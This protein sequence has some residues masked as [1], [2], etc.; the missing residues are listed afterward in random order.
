[1]STI[2]R[3]VG[4]G[5]SATAG[6]TVSVSSFGALGNG[7][8]DDTNAIQAAINAV[9][10][11]ATSIG[12]DTGGVV[13]FPLG[14]YRC[15]AKLSVP[16]FVY[17][18]GEAAYASKLICD[19]STTI[20]RFIE[21]GATG[22]ISTFCGLK[23]LQVDANAK[24][25]VAVFLNGP[26][27]GA[28]VSEVW[29]K[30]ARVTGI[31]VDADTVLGTANKFLVERCWIWTAGDT[32][33]AGMKAEG[34]IM[35]VRSTTFVGTLRSGTYPTGGPAGSAGII[36]TDGGM[37]I[38]DVNCEHWEAAFSLVRASVELR[39]VTAFAV[40]NGVR[41][42]ADN[43]GKS[44]FLTNAKWDCSGDDIVDTGNSVSLPDAG[45]YHRGVTVGQ[46]PHWR[47]NWYDYQTVV[48]G[49]GNSVK[50]KVG[51]QSDADADLTRFK[52]SFLGP[53]GWR[54]A[55]QIDTDYTNGPASAAWNGAHLRMGAYHLWI[56]ATG[57][58]RI[59]ASAPTSDTDGTV[60]GTQT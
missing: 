32:G 46:P 42:S 19:S 44:W 34:G 21:F 8:T 47:A 38:D 41:T 33:M 2:V 7:T 23:S 15:T 40:T 1:M 50:T 25:D 18:V 11:R 30:G 5:G 10:A 3:T 4:A 37:V 26:Q 54:V 59:K 35:T 60:V 31:E 43:A 6:S 16:K 36:I 9:A 53:S 22:Q 27:E 17:L 51:Y 45:S 57:D 56:D 52:T 58:L 12:P 55:H 13:Y 20:A 29:V 48:I 24:A 39:S 49:T 28:T 14:R